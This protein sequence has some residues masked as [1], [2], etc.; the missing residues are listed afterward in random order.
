MLKSTVVPASGGLAAREGPAVFRG[1]VATG[2]SAA[3][4][5]QGFRKTEA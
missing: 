5:P 3:K 4:R 1:K 2:L